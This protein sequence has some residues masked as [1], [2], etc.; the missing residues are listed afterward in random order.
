MKKWRLR[1]V[2][3]VLCMSFFGVLQVHAEEIQNN[4]TAKRINRAEELQLEEWIDEDGYLID[5]FFEGKS[6]AEVS[7]MNLDGIVRTLSEEEVDVISSQ[8]RGGLKSFVVNRY[9]KVSQLNPDTGRYL[10]TGVFEVDGILAFCIE[11]DMVTPP[12]GSPTGEWIAVSNENMRKVLY[13]GYNGPAAKGYTFVETAMAVAEANGHGDNSMGRKVLAEIIQLESPPEEFKAWK[14]E[15]ND[16]STQEL[17]FY[18]YEIAEGIAKIQKSSANTSITDG[19]GNY[20]LLEAEYAIY[21]DSACKEEVGYFVTDA[22]GTSN[23][24]SLTP[25]TYYVK[26]LVAPQGYELNPEVKTVTVETEQ[27]AVLEVEDMP[28]VIKPELILQKVDKDTGLSVAQGNASLEDARFLVKYYVNEQ[29]LSGKAT[30]EWIL[31]TDKEGKI[32]LETEYLVSGDDFWKNASGENVFPLGIITVEEIQAPKGYTTHPG[33]FVVRLSEKRLVF[34]TI[35]VE[36]TITSLELVKYD[37]GFSKPLEGAE[38]LLKGPNGFEQKVT[39]DSLGKVS[40]KGLEVGKYLLEETKAPLGYIRNRNII[41]FEIAAE[42]TIRLLSQGDDSF[43]KVVVEHNLIKIENR[44]GYQLPNTGSCLG[45]VCS[46]AGA[47]SL[48]ISIA[49]KRR[50]EL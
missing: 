10:Y 18:T 25:G 9:L 39:T 28:K 41:E 33:V 6:D 46:M 4:E 48:M 23:G 50:R 1:T 34:D 17:A 3:L 47:G 38:F 27:T 32:K 14:V 11:R 49:N 12:Q 15:T 40:W 13:Y 45:M 31:K 2:F 5:S 24:V 26:E 21:S 8:L 7:N 35:R 22:T 43:G 16:G 37:E 44:I 20:A 29:Q 19:N 30:R 42:G 36:E